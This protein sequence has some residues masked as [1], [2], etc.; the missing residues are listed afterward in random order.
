[1]RWLRPLKRRSMPLVH[2]TLRAHALAQAG[3][4]E[5]IDRA[6]FEHAGADAAFAIR[7]AARLDD[8]RFDAVPREQMRQQKPGRAG[9]HDPDLRP[10][11][12]RRHASP[13]GGA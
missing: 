1:M 5:E 9:A 2:E 4:V 11:R 8:D 10:Q 6:L 7:A 13:F 3:L 12:F